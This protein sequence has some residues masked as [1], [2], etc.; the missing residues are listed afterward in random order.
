MAA[1]ADSLCPDLFGTCDEV[2]KHTE[3]LRFAQFGA[4]QVRVLP[5]MLQVYL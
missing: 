4:W 2:H 1:F 5:G 3:E